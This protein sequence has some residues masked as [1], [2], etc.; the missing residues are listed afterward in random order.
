MKIPLDP[1]VAKRPF[2]ANS[3]GGNGA[4]DVVALAQTGCIK[5]YKST[6]DGEPPSDERTRDHQQQRIDRDLASPILLRLKVWAAQHL[7]RQGHVVETEAIEA[8]DHSE[9]D[10]RFD[11]F[12]KAVGD[13]VFDVGCSCDDETTVV[14]VGDVGY[15]RLLDSFGYTQH[16][17][18]GDV[19]EV[20]QNLERTHET[21]IDTYC[22]FPR[23]SITGLRDRSMYVFESGQYPT[24]GDS[25]LDSDGRRAGP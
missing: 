7:D 22:I 19:E 23:F 15:R 9:I 8:N 1:R 10:W 14:D 24:D 16:Q 20:L 3:A 11:C 4:I 12:D 25:V 17:P 2:E 5:V 18:D 6:V 21:G 13:L